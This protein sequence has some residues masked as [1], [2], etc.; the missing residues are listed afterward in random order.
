MLRF[1]VGRAGSGKSH[2][3]LKEMS[4]AY[5]NKKTDNL[6]LL[7]PEQYSLEAS[8]DFMD[9]M[10]QHGHIHMDVLSFKRLAHRVFFEETGATDRV[11]ISE[12][13]K[14]MLLRRY[15]RNM[16]LT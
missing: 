9:K 1:I 16:R 8:A 7:I 6:I 10:G 11:Q 4:A 12:L 13:G 5:D 15:L 14:T 3:I 2:R